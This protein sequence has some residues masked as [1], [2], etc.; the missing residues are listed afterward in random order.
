MNRTIEFSEGEYYHLYNRGVEKRKIFLNDNDR[1]RFLRLL[2]LSNG[3]RPFVYRE[4]Q[5]KLLSEIDRGETLVAIGAYCLMPNHFHILVRE[6]RPNGISA[7]M[8]KFSTGYSK[9]FNIKRKRVGPLFQSR[10]KAEHVD[11]DEYLKYLFSYIHLNPVKIIEPK[12]TEVGI[13]D[14]KKA[15]LYLKNYRYSSYPDYLAGETKRNAILSPEEF[16]EYFETKNDFA[17]ETKDWLQF[18]NAFSQDVLA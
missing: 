17:L 13:Q 14:R 16:P 12:W 4:L 3:T 9:Y 5:S 1:D 11:D 2:Y 10:F 18:A 6:I 15:E 7:F 8:E